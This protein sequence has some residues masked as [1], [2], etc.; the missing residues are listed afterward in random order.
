MQNLKM[1]GG[2]LLLGITI[3]GIHVRTPAI[4]SKS[5]KRTILFIISFFIAILLFKFIFGFFPYT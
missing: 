5:E 1:I 3:T 2:L 4:V